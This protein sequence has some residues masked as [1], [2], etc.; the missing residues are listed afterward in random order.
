M[1]LSKQAFGPLNIN[2]FKVPSRPAHHRAKME[3]SINPFGD[4]LKA[5]R[6]AEISL[7]NFSARVLQRRGLS[8]RSR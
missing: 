3:H 1:A 2:T 4:T 8:G 7:A 5:S 6:D